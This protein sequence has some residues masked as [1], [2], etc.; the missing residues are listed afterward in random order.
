MMSVSG[1]AH[2]ASDRNLLFGILALQLD[3]ITRDALIQA[4]NAWVLDKGKPLGQ[5]L[6]E[7][8]ALAAHHDALLQAL[9]QEHLKQ[10]GN[11]PKK[12]LEALS[13]VGPEHCDLTQIH[14]L[15]ASLDH[16]SAV[17]FAE[18]ASATRSYEAVGQATAQRDWTPI[19]TVPHVPAANEAVGESTSTGLR[20]R[21]LR[22]YAKGGLGQVSVARD[23][24]LHREVALKEMQDQFANDALARAR[25][26]Q[27][28]EITGSLEHPGIVP[29]YGLGHYEDGRPFYAMRFIRG[30]SLKDAIERFHRPDS[31]KDAAEGTLQLRD[32]LGRF[33]DVCNAIAYAHSR[34]VLH[35]DLKPGN[36]MLG[37]YGET[38]VVDWGLAK[39]AGSRWGVC[40]SDEAT[41]RPSSASGSAVTVAGTAIGTPAYMSPEQ[42]AG[43]LDQLG[44][45]TD[46]YSLGATLYTLLTGAS[47]FPVT[48]L[49]DSLKKVQAGDFAKPRKLR[50][51][52][53][54]AL[55]AIC[56]KAMALQPE[57][58][59]RSPRE[60]ATDIEHWLADESVQAYAESWPMRLAR[61]GRR[62]RAVV[63][64]A[65]ALLVTAVIA[66]GI[67]MALLRQA[68]FRTQEQ[69]DLA[70]SNLEEA[71]RQKNIAETSLERTQVAE[72]R[73]RREAGK[74]QAI[75]KFLTHDLLEE[76]RPERNARDKKVTLEEI[77]NRAGQKLDKAFAGQ[78]DVEAA[79]RTTIGNTFYLLGAFGPAET[80]LRRALALQQS[81]L[82]PEHHDTLDTMSS[83]AELCWAAG[84]LDDSIDLGRRTLATAKKTLGT[85]D[86][87]TMTCMNNLSLAL[88]RQGRL[89]EAESL[90]RATLDIRRRSLG[91]EH[92][93]TLNALNNLA[94]QLMDQGKARQAEPLLKQALESA[95]RALGHN[96][97]LNLAFTVNYGAL[98][99]DLGRYD[100]A[101]AILDGAIKDCIRIQGAE[102]PYTLIARNNLN[103]L[104]IRQGRAREAEPLCRQNLEACRSVLGSTHQKTLYACDNLVEN[105][106]DQGRFEEANKL[107][108][109]AL[110]CRRSTLERLVAVSR[111]LGK[112]AEAKD[113]QSKLETTSPAPSKDN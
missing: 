23:L 49:E 79:L 63:A 37:N 81:L 10:H 96:D 85:N 73:A 70:R 104:L 35:R 48:T 95:K 34:G 88:Q 15:Q 13:T 113:W 6:V 21:V 17:P 108:S 75:N 111:A 29:V 92:P 4:M 61:W 59:Y 66:M 18:D 30:D 82:G 52:T 20:F 1:P 24:E 94:R 78:P 46:V 100:E 110:N 43:R 53:P 11:D 93:Y 83:L 14:D 97:P 36:I 89:A 80:H 71:R 87:L 3:F 9:A 12:S 19:K 67:G 101:K 7:Q 25:F 112:E 109:E 102:H 84:K 39:P 56:L 68:N 77:V 62:H 28:A 65:A 86:K 31:P 50:P 58:R 8:G 2:T 64:S 69:R 72:Q 98:L 47:P 107:S 27:E 54:A 38:L 74:A 51:G 26:L 33:V 16:V 105:L 41:L 55:E 106:I 60:L 99:T 22:Q 90:C 42:A 40:V 45:A 76:A 44:P 32:L 5:I 91:Q 57:D 103:R